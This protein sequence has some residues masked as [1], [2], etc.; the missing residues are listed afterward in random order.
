MPGPAPSGGETE[1]DYSAQPWGGECWTPLGPGGLLEGCTLELGQPEEVRGERHSK[2]RKP[3]VRRALRHFRGLECRWEGHTA[4]KETAA[5]KGLSP[6][7]G[8]RGSV[9][10]SWPHGHRVSYI[11][12][13]LGAEMVLR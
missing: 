7:R 8:Q 13:S 3:S 5:P 2:L 4:R 10:V 9:P 12:V 1:V 6:G 11:H